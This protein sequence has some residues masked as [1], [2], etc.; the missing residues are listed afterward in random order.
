M[1]IERAEADSL[2]N[3]L[4]VLSGTL[5]VTFFPMELMIIVTF[6]SELFFVIEVIAFAQS[7]LDHYDQVRRVAHLSVEAALSLV[8]ELNYNSLLK[9]KASDPFEESDLG[10][11][12]RRER[13]MQTGV[14]CAS[15]IKPPSRTRKRTDLSGPAKKRSKGEKQG[16]DSIGD[17]IKR[18]NLDEEDSHERSS[19]QTTPE[20]TW[21]EDQETQLSPSSYRFFQSGDDVWK[22][23][24]PSLD[25][26]VFAGVLPPMESSESLRISKTTEGHDRALDH[27]DLAELNERLRNSPVTMNTGELPSTAVTIPFLGDWRIWTSGMPHKDRLTRMKVQRS[28]RQER[29]QRRRER[30]F[31]RR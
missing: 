19:P 24:R 30:A 15:E 22:Y 21:G 10:S 13:E 25:D 16:P 28:R 23:T 29:S 3:D 9:R 5:K 31:V 12:K 7:S 20:N 27:E 1:E 11:T 4:F 14:I 26:L 8:K 2:I 6:D 18:R 17:S